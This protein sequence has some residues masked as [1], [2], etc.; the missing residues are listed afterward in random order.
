MSD[1]KKHKKPTSSHPFDVWPPPPKP[2]ELVQEENLPRNP[3]YKDLQAEYTEEVPEIYEIEERPESKEE[4]K[5][6]DKD[7]QNR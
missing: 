3:S 5:E 7:S 4:D 6:N 1:N 2:D